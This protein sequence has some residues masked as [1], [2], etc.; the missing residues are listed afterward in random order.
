[1][2]KDNKDNQYISLK[3][4]SE[5]SDYSQDYLSLRARQGKLKAVKLGRNW[6]TTK[7]WFNEYTNKVNEYKEK[8]SKN[9]I[10][11]DTDIKNIDTYTENQTNNISPK[12]CNKRSVL[13]HTIIAVTILVFILF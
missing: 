2:P 1:M 10:K 12:S 9:N 11:K 8:H 7:E 5:F 3:E 13:S 4:M 6:V